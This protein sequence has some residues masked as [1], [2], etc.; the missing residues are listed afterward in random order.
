MGQQINSFYLLLR[1]IGAFSASLRLIVVGF[2][3]L[4][5]A[6]AE[7]IVASVCI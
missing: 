7:E 1:K 3:I 6:V 2:V 5:V 4:L